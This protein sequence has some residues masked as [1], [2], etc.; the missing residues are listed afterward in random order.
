[1]QP[2]PMSL[3]SE[4]QV[5]RE[6][7]ESVRRERDELRVALTSKSMEC[8][9]TKEELDE[10]LRRIKVLEGTHRSKETVSDNQETEVRFCPCI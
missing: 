2:V 6:S 8:E 5:L 3:E 9:R 7:V 4:I 1:M 10:A